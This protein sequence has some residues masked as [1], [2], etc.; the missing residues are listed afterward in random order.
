VRLDSIVG[1]S[2]FG[3]LHTCVCGK[4]APRTSISSSAWVPFVCIANVD[5]EIKYVNRRKT[6]VFYKF[7]T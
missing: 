2:T 7:I 5:R 1:G 4:R 6:A 3:R